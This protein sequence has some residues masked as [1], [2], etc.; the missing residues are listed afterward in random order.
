MTFP[1]PAVRRAGTADAQAITEV[2]SSGFTL[3]PPL[4]WIIPD[5]TERAALSPAFFAPFVE[6]VV[7]GGHAYVTDDGTGAHSGSTWT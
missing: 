3:D 2:L 7:S 6:L 5:P 1:R 4:V